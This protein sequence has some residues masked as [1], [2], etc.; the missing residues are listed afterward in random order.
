M[1]SALSTAISQADYDRAEHDI[2]SLAKNFAT[3]HPIKGAMVL[4]CIGFQP[5]TRAIQREIDIPVFSWSTL[6]DYAYSV[7]AHRDFY[8]HV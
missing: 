8:G 7:A 1:P 3:S 2:V 4:E 5:Y 6:L